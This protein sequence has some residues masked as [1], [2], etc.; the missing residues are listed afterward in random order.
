MEYHKWTLE[1][2]MYFQEDDPTISKIYFRRMHIMP[3]SFIYFSLI[4][5]KAHVQN[6]YIH[7]YLHINITLTPYSE[8]PSVLTFC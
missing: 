3:I 2:F 8:I 5:M 1:V 4:Y 6:M 7:T